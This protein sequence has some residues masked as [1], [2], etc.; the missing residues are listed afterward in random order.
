MV[1]NRA[2]TSGS[3]S[4]LVFNPP[5]L[6]IRTA[7][8]IV[9]QPGIM[10]PRKYQCQVANET[11]TPQVR[12]ELFNRAGGQCECT[13]AVCQHHR[14]NTR[15]PNTLRIGNWDAHRRTAGGV[16]EL[17]NLLAMCKECHPNTRTYGR[18]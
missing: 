17:W 13:M 14:A 16:Y 11:L 3:P 18:G 1:R 9:V 15:C 7:V 10:F 2:Y 12:Q 6:R 8:S 5:G 4:G